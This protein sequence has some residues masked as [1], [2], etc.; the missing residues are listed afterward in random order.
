MLQRKSMKSCLIKTKSNGRVYGTSLMW[1]NFPHDN[2]LNFFYDV[3]YVGY[4]Q[5]LQA[6]FYVFEEIQS[7]ISKL[8]QY[9][10]II[11][12][13]NANESV[14]FQL[15]G[16][17]IFI[18]PCEPWDLLV[19]RDSEYNYVINNYYTSN[20]NNNHLSYPYVYDLKTFSKF[21]NIRKENLIF[22]QRRSGMIENIENF[23]VLTEG[24]VLNVSYSAWDKNRTDY[25]VNL[26]RCKYAYSL[27]VSPSPGQVI[28]E[29]ALVGCLVF[30][31]PQKIFA[32][33][34]LPEF[35]IVQNEQ[36]VAQ[37]IKIL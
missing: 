11:F 9:D 36:E 21:R 3:S 23:S 35:C 19:N 34:L 16:K 28:A 27:C 18:I 5:A 24:Q 31:T 4:I 8:Y 30:S 26:S 6:D 1:E 2:F 32:K 37:K 12:L 14:P 29:A 22:R 10:I 25:L 7:D 17:K 20:L 13:S 33:H 15:Q